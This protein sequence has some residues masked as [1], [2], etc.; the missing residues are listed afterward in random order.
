MRRRAITPTIAMVAVLD[1]SVLKRADENSA[2][3]ADAFLVDHGD[4][5][6]GGSRIRGYSDRQSSQGGGGPR[7]APGLP[8]LAA[9]RGT[10]S[11]QVPAK[12]PQAKPPIFLANSLVVSKS[13]DTA[14]K[15]HLEKLDEP[16]VQQAIQLEQSLAQTE[17]QAAG[18]AELHRRRPGYTA[19]PATGG[20]IGCQGR[21]AFAPIPH[22][23][24]PVRFG[25]RLVGASSRL[26]SS[27]PAEPPVI[28]SPPFFA[29]WP[30]SFSSASTPSWKA[31]RGPSQRF[32]LPRT[33]PIR[34][35]W[36]RYKKN[37]RPCPNY[38]KPKFRLRRKSNSRRIIK[39]C[40]CC[41]NV[42]C[43]RKAITGAN[44]KAPRPPGAVARRQ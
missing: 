37:D 23:R 12:Q 34:S 11:A 20:G 2:R 43:V 3:A 36:N 26:V 40:R 39:G 10:G 30:S 27:P 42:S 8:G 28:G 16:Y 25:N 33:P 18:P 31:T 15:Q 24:D 41:G 21:T 13:L 6:S 22:L 44:A 35:L 17:K 5:Q 14:D 1:E 7:S 38:R 4:S 32:R 29:F 19:P 9:F